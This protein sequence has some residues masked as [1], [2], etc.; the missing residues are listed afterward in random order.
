MDAE[1]EDDD[2]EF[3]HK[4]FFWPKSW[5]KY[6]MTQKKRLTF[7]LTGGYQNND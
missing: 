4:A 7:T 6:E 1:L 3:G 2:L 5:P